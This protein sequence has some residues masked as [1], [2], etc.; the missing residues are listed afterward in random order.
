MKGILFLLVVLF[1]S[2]SNSSNHKPEKTKEDFGFNVYDYQSKSLKELEKLN[3]KGVQE[4]GFKIRGFD[5]AKK[6]LFKNGD[7]EVI[8]IDGASS[9]ITFNNIK[10]I[11]FA[12]C[13]IDYF[14]DFDCKN[15]SFKNDIT[16]RWNN[17]PNIR[18]FSLFRRYENG[19]A[20]TVVD[21][22]YVNFNVEF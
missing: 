11:E 21:R 17:L 19:K 22:A 20:L 18:E 12:N 3:G 4:I 13:S 8:F 10:D 5:N 6:Y 16:I 7:I 14:G 9:L 15:R 1:Y 2:C